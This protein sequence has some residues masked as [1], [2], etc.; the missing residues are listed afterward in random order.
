[1]NISQNRFAISLLLVISI[2]Q[3]MYST[4]PVAHAFSSVCSPNAYWKF[5]E[6]SGTDVADSSGNALHGTLNETLTFS[7]ETAPTGFTNLRS[8]LFDQTQSQRVYTSKD[9]TTVFSIALWLKTDG[10]AHSYGTLAAENTATGLYYRGDDSGTPNHLSYYDSDGIDHMNTTALS[11]GEWH[12]VVLTMNS[13]VVT[14]YVDGVEDGTAVVAGNSFTI[15]TIGGDDSDE[16]FHGYIDDVRV[17]DDLLTAEDISALAQGTACLPTSSSSASSVA[18]STQA[19]AQQGGSRRAE[20]MKNLIEAA[21]KKLQQQS[22]VRV[23]S[24]EESLHPAAPL[25]PIRKNTQMRICQRIAKWK[26]K[27]AS[28]RDRINA[29]LNKRF[30]FTC[31]G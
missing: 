11:L 10:V 12:H 29:R 6:S 9:V 21:Q 27:N 18:T 2:V 5:D 31:D 22:V 26:E 8:F 20:S 23:P 4:F 30:G 28:I 13:G 15:A 7:T 3:M 16:N 24:N 1:M 25:L 19:P 17:Y 14:F